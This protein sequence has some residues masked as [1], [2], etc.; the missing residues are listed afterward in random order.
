MPD[1][2]Y[3]LDFAGELAPGNYER[4]GIAGY[5]YG[6]QQPATVAVYRWYNKVS[7][8]HFYTTDPAGELAPQ[9]YTYEGVAWYMFKDKQ[10]NNVP[11]YRWYNSQTG[12]HFYTTDANG[13]LGPPAYKSEGV[14]GYLHP[15]PTTHAVPVYRWYESGLLSNFTFEDDITESQRRK[16][17]ERHTWAYYRAGICGNITQEEKDKVRAVYREG[18]HH[19]ATTMAGVNAYV[20]NLGARHL[21]IHFGNLFPQGDRE[22]AQ[23]LLHE[24]M[25]CAGYPHPVRIDSGPNIDRPYDGGKYYGTAPLRSEMCIDGVQSDTS[26][27]GLELASNAVTQ[28]ERWACPVVTPA[29]GTGPNEGNQNSQL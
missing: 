14:L 15:H 13:E 7:H 9:N 21:F 17:L 6:S 5:V 24:M 20:P 18:V 1:H 25:H 28:F 4:E 19:S 16:L 22:I 11:L 29:E 27:V 3:T 2:F 26:T 8:D 23:T 12:D 10:A